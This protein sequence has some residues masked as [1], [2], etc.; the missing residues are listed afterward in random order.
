MKKIILLFA[1][2]S[3]ASCDFKVSTPKDAVHTNAK[4]KVKTRFVNEKDMVCGM[5]VTDEYTD[6]VIVDGAKYGFCSPTC[7]NEFQTNT[8]QYLKK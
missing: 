4:P 5:D 6:S 2:A 8:K 7:S 1:I 3:L